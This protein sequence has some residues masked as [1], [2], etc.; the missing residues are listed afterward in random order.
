MRPSWSCSYRHTHPSGTLLWMCLSHASA[1]LVARSLRCSSALA[2]PHLT[3]GAPS[4]DLA[5]PKWAQVHQLPWSSLTHFCGHIAP[6]NMLLSALLLCQMRA[7]RKSSDWVSKY[8]GEL[9]GC[10]IHQLQQ[11][12]KGER[13]SLQ[14]LLAAMIPGCAYHNS[15]HHLFLFI[16]II[17]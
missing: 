11:T 1:A 10:Q 6:F 9:K 4:W 17:Y 7:L 14:S 3:T 5:L 15:G 16:C 12:N 8:S 13:L 2:S